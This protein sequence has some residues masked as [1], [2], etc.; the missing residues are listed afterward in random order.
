MQPAGPTSG[1]RRRCFVREMRLLKYHPPIFIPITYAYHPTNSLRNVPVPL[2][3]YP[4][5]DLGC[6]LPGLGPAVLRLSH[7]RGPYGPHI[8]A[9][10]WP[11]VALFVRHAGPVL[12]YAYHPPYA[13]SGTD[14]AYAATRTWD[15]FLWAVLMNRQVQSAASTALRCLVLSGSDGVDRRCC[16]DVR[17]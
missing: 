9:S 12:S 10:A 15:V 1:G 8:R 3:P 13:L 6:A 2:T 4:G 5:T 14:T 16:Y 11:F 7:Q 17:Y